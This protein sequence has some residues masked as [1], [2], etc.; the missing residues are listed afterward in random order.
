M[1]SLA[2]VALLV[3]FAAADKKTEDFPVAVGTK[4]TFT[5]AEVK[6]T[7]TTTLT[8]DA[9]LVQYTPHNDVIN[10]F[11]KAGF[12][13]A[14]DGIYIVGESLADLDQPPPAPAKAI[15]LPF[16]KGGTGKV[17]G[18]IETTYTV[19]A[20]ESVKVPAGAYSAWAASEWNA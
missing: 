20:K 16:K 18:M 14:A 3:G 10:W 4:L 8:G 5:A 7:W 6:D 13:V 19:G 2:I 11:S 1:R 15:A 12:R 17:P 9:K